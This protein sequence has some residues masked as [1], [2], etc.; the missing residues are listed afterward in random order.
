MSIKILVVDD[1]PLQ[2]EILKTI[3]SGEGYETETAES[4]EVALAML[5]KLDPEVILTD[6]QMTGMGGLEFLQSLPEKSVPPAVIVIT[7]H[8]TISSAVE[9][10]RLGAADYLTKPVDKEKILFAVQK[11]S[12]RSRILKENLR[13]RT[14]LFSRF[15]IDGIVGVSPPIRQIVDILRRVADSSSTIMIRGESGTG[16]ELIARA[17]HYNSPRCGRPFTALNCAAIPENLFE[18]ELFG[19][20]AGAFTGATGRREGLIEA[21]QG[22][23][24]FLDEVGDMPLTMQSKLLRVLQDREIRRIG[25]KETIRVDLRILSATNKNLEE[26][27]EKGTFREDLYYRL[28][29]VFIEM[30]PLRERCEDIP[31]LVAAFVRKYNQEFGRRVND[32]SREALKALV[33]YRW[34]GNVRQLEAVIERSVLLSDGGTLTL[35][36]IGG[37]LVGRKTI[38]SLG[39]DLPEE[40]LNF[41]ELEKDLLQKALQR[42]GGVASKAAKLLKM[43][44]KTFLYRIEKFG[45]K[46]EKDE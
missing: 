20:E 29:V 3:L 32:V 37:L 1:E 34:P 8:G 19:Y 45:L 39:I 9:A 33:E 23:T 30:P 40:G 14:E 28:N 6:L 15:K 31:D 46:A 4:A 41:E 21:T 13:L 7:A 22:G 11:A 38:N 18:S 44:Y 26:E 5:K 24:L 2:R 43:S 12:E 17:V 42:T 25:G 16:K 27:V 10:V 36:D 35:D